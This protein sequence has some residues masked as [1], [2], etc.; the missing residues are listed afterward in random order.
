MNGRHSVSL[1]LPEKVPAALGQLVPISV[2]VTDFSGTDREILVRL[3]GSL[4]G[5][6]PAVSRQL[7]AHLSIQTEVSLQVP[8]GMPVGEHPVLIEVL[9]RSTGSVIGQ[10]EVLLDVQHTQAIRM[11]LSPPSIRR[12]LRGRIR[13]VLRNHDDET[14]NIRI[15]AESD[16]S[17][18]KIKL[19]HQDV[20]LRAGEMVRLKA[21]LRVKP[22]FIGKQKEHWYSIIGDGAGVPI[23]GRGNVRHIPMI[24]RNI[25]SLMGLMC[26]VLVWAGATLAIIKAV[27]P[28]TTESTASAEE[29]GD[30]TGE[31][32]ADSGGE[33]E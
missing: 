25:K 14:H 28:V 12:R 19:W 27:N 2:G 21:R 11:H 10:G 26:I 15:R 30:D 29:G 17:H 9:D 32:G 23:Y 22:F 8:S 20:E 5:P 31:S 16:D 6:L 13:I 33:L 18:T 7:P 4:T 3:I 24:G 1:I